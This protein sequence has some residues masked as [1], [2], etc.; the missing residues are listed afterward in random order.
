MP[1]PLNVGHAGSAQVDFCYS[2][3]SG[4]AEDSRQHYLQASLVEI[5]TLFLS[6]D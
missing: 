5:S 1:L 2:D 4:D 3:G 6:I